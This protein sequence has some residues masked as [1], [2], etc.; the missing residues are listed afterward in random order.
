MNKK[1]VAFA[2]TLMLLLSFA[3]SNP[4]SVYASAKSSSTVSISVIIDKAEYYDQL[5]SWLRSIDFKHFTFVIDENYASDYILNN[6]TRLNTLKSYGEIIPRLPYIQQFTTIE[7]MSWIDDVTDKYTAKLGAAPKGIMDFVPDTFSASYALSKGYTY[8]QGYC[9]DQYA[10]DAIS[11]IGGWQMP[12]YASSK[13]TLIPNSQSGGIVILPHATADWLDS[14]TVWQGL[15]LH[16]MNI[17]TF[18]NDNAAM[19]K[20]YF[21]EL[22]DNILKSCS[23][24]SFANVQFEW[25]WCVDRGLIN[26]AKDWISSILTHRGISAPYQ[27]FDY[28]DFVSW[29]KSAYSATPEYR[30]LFT[31]PY[32]GDSIEWYYSS[33]FRVARVGAYVVSFVDYTKQRNDTYLTQTQHIDWSGSLTDPNNC[34]DTSLAIAISALGGGLM[35]YPALDAQKVQYTGDL[36]QFAFNYHS[37]DDIPEIDASGIVALV[38][39]VAAISGILTRR[40][41][42]HTRYRHDNQKLRKNCIRTSSLNPTIH[43]YLF[44]F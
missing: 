12:Y 27:V 31:S 19:A 6:A 22:T 15:Q 10:V 18:F 32:R 28:A 9:L 7:R 36:S 2:F 3:S 33:A 26:T 24:V 44:L 21:L 11:E 30:V 29:F 14:F 34:V 25:S 1:D 43:S 42:Q 39:I 13:H 41:C 37:T 20:A 8:I 5:S 17:M 40:H 16:P 38:I 23:P 35:R 4:K